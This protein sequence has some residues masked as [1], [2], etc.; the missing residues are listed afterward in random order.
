KIKTFQVLADKLGISKERVRQL[1]QR[2]VAKLQ[3][4]ASTA[5]LAN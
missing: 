1:E 4:L 2:A 5:T 3:A